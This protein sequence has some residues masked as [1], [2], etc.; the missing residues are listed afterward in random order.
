LSSQ[1]IGMVL[2]VQRMTTQMSLILL[3]LFSLTNGSKSFNKL[4]KPITIF[5]IKT[6]EQKSIIVPQDDDAQEGGA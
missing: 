3:N 5:I 1:G 4:V 2:A 6:E